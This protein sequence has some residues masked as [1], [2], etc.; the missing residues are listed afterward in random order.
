MLGAGRKDKRKDAGR[1][2]RNHLSKS[3][4]PG[5]FKGLE[6]LKT[7]EQTGGCPQSK[8]SYCRGAGELLLNG[9]RVSVWK[10]LEMDGGGDGCLT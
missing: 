1:D 7:A 2:K 8:V 3:A 5:D 4:S 6:A 10:V 9:N